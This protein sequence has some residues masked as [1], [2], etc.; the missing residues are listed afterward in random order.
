MVYYAR[1][2]FDLVKQTIENGEYTYHCMTNDIEINFQIINFTNS[3][4]VNEAVSFGNDT[5]DTQMLILKFHGKLT[6]GKNGIIIPAVRKKG[7][8][9]FCSGT[10]TNNG[11]ISM[12]ARGANAVGQDVYL[13][14]KEFVPAVGGAGASR[15]RGHAHGLKGSDGVN[16][17]T[18][19]GGSGSAMRENTYSGTGTAGT[20]YSGGSGGG[21]SSSASDSGITSYDAG[22]NGGAGGA[23]RGRRTSLTMYVSSGGAGNP[24][25]KDA[26]PTSGANVTVGGNAPSS[27]KEGTGG[28]LIIYSQNIYNVGTIES[29]G[30]AACYP[31]G[32]NTSVSCS[33]GSSGG[34]SINIFYGNELTNNGSIIANGGKTIVGA[35]YNGGDGGD[36]TVNYQAIEGIPLLSQIIKNDVYNTMTEVLVKKPLTNAEIDNT[37]LISVKES[38]FRTKLKESIG[39]NVTT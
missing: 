28:L 24:S 1:T 39:A 13:Y 33:G 35:G 2:I 14:D 12:T 29:S 36:G 27:A 15:V 8:V 21:G 30:S 3:V 5:K 7:M 23:A 20:S 31:I 10:L 6:V 11:T 34:G 25:G 38:A 26:R 32:Y 17:L 18:G 4:E 22:I 37:D 9:I 19:G 16:R